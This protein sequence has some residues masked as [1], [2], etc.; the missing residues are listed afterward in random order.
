[1]IQSSASNFVE[2]PEEEVDNRS[3]YDR[4]QEQK[5]KKQEEFDES[6]KL[7]ECHVSKV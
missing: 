2:A 7:S 5:L 6:R 1:M 4:L 3:L